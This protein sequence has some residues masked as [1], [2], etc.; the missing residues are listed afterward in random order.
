M[1][2]QRR[3]LS[4]GQVLLARQPVNAGVR[5]H[6]SAD[7][8]NMWDKCKIKVQETAVFLLI[9]TF[10]LLIFSGCSLSETKITPAENAFQSIVGVPIEPDI[11]L[12]TEKDQYSS[13]DEIGIWVRN[14]TKNELLFE[15]QSLGLKAY[16]YDKQK[17]VWNSIDL[18][19]TLADPYQVAIKP[20]PR[21]L[22]PSISIPVEW[23]KAS[24]EI[25]LVIVGLTNQGKTVAAFKDIT[26]TR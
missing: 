12:L 26:I 2:R 6:V 21:A 16:Q 20:G 3:H 18:G 23:I 14:D 10:A 17:E 24:G 4:V 5:G 13:Q 1:V 19:F 15:D 25:R 11:S 22:L 8:K 9:I 7:R